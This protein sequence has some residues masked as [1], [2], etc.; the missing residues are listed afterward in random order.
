M[1]ILKQKKNIKKQKDNKPKNLS[2]YLKI[3]SKL[4][5]KHIKMRKTNKTIKPLGVG[6][7]NKFIFN[8]KFK[9]LKATNFRKNKPSGFK[10][11]F[12]LTKK[13]KQKKKFLI[14]NSKRSKKK[15]KN[16]PLNLHSNVNKRGV[17]K[18]NPPSGFAFKIYNYKFKMR[19]KLTFYNFSLF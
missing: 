6:V 13:P 11:K 12:Y 17:I 14:K 15:I 9:G 7:A 1:H 2:A 5:N 10:N 8:V 3:Q 18:L 4:V 19:Q 16:Q